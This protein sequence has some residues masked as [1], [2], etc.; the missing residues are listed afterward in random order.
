MHVLGLIQ[1]KIPTLPR[2][3]PRRD[4]HM[5]PTGASLEVLGCCAM[6][7]A[8]LGGGRL[9]TGA[10]PAP[11]WGHQGAR[12]APAEPWNAWASGQMPAWQGQ[13]TE[14][15]PGMLTGSHHGALPFRNLPA[16]GFLP[17]WG[18]WAPGAELPTGR[19]P[20]TSQEPPGPP[21]GAFSGVS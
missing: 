6:E 16:L 2:G 12:Q 7:G 11:H 5:G 15:V 17:A 9:A 3:L 13:G 1:G 4:G 21:P 19:Q 18:I 10:A 8:G 14:G 20:R